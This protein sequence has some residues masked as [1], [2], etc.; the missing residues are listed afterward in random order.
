MVRAV[1]PSKSLPTP[2]TSE[3]A[4]VVTSVAIGAP[5]ALF[6]DVTAPIAPD[7]FVPVAST[8]ENETIVIEETVVCDSVAVTVTLVIIAGAKARQISDVPRCA[9]VRP[10]S[11]HV[12]PAP[13]TLDTDVLVPV[14]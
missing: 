11:T 3:F 13:V 9:F 10:T 8:L 7:P 5:D 2:N 1:A 14:T 4:R 12:R 6:A